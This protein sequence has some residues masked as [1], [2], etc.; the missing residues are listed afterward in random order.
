MSLFRPAALSGVFAALV[1]TGMIHAQQPQVSEPPTETVPTAVPT[2]VP[3]TVPAAVAPPQ[4]PELDCSL[5]GARSRAA[6]LM[7]ALQQ[8]YGV[9]YWGEGYDA[10][11]LAAQPHGLLIVEVTKTGAPYT[12]TGQELFFTPE[13]ITA[14]RHD[15]SRPTLGYLNVSEIETYRDYWIDQIGTTAPGTLPEWYGPTAGHGDHLA[16]YWTQGWRDILLNRVDRL[17]QT[18]VDGLFLDDVLH[19][20]SHALDETLIWPE[21]QRPDGPTGAPAL[22]Q[23]MMALVRTVADRARLWNCDAFI[24]VNN[25]VFIGRDAAGATPGPAERAGFGAY[26]DAIDAVMVENVSAPT[27]HIHTIEALQQ[28]F[29]DHGVAV[30]SLDVETQFPEQT[31]DDLRAKITDKARQAGFYPYVSADAVFNRLTPP[32]LLP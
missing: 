14:I 11:T 3:A 2:A 12:E 19:Y 20:Y 30:L 32:I 4:P 24:V 1:P 23:G 5:A 8:G 18:G 31:T 15:G 29:R 16:A 26:L 22:A 13:E 6:R 25:G 27:T 28:D 17:M 9:Q 7:P 10:T 21:G